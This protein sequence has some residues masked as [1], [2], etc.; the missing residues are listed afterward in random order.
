[1]SISFSQLMA[2]AAFQ[3]GVLAL[4]IPG[5]WMQGRTTY[6]GLSA[7]LCLETARRAFPDAPPLRSALVSF[8]GP[9]G[10]PV[11]GRAAMLRQGRSVT[12]VEA[13]IS[14]EKG[15]ATR[16][17]FAFGGARPSQW[18]RTFTAQ[19]AMPAP[20]DCAPFIPEGMGPPFARHFDARLAKGGRPA[21]GSKAHDHFI[22]VRHK[23][24]G[25]D[26]VVALLALA[27]MPPP[28]LMPMF[29]EF[30]P[31][32]SMTWMVNM[33]TD[34]PATRDGWWLMESRAEQA[35]DGY[36]SQDM[37][38]WNRDG[39]LVIAGRQSVAIFA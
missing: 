15:I 18:N 21:T 25:A 33:L 30:A 12:F 27:D 28:A 24:E 35:G 5:E 4:T 36:S 26:G 2:S 22:W 16:C 29:T 10:G 38:V 9:A 39:E 14:G 23:D 19:P 1:M 37:L 34:A 11:T 20:E 3:D 8:I 32:S 13:D 7:A 6:G 31:I 17:A